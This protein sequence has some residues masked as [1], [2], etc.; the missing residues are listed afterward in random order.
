MGLTLTPNKIPNLSTQTQVTKQKLN[1][2]VLHK[3]QADPPK[4]DRLFL[5][6]HQAFAQAQWLASLRNRE[7][8]SRD[9]IRLVVAFTYRVVRIY[10][11]FNHVVSRR[12]VP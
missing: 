1:L 9:V 10:R 8:E 4:A 7:I 12:D 3:V 11:D 5:I 2:R 6:I